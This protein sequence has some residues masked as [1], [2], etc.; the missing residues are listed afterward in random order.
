M[1]K[2][3]NWHFKP[4]RLAPDRRVRVVEYGRFQAGPARNSGRGKNA[5]L[6]WFPV[7]IDDDYRDLDVPRRGFPSAFKVSLLDGQV[8]VIPNPD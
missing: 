2:F 1:V 4:E 3:I 6:D 5:I 7:P 8:K